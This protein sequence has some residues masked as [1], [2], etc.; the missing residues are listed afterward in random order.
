MMDTRRPRDYVAYWLSRDA[1]RA[2]APIILRFVS[3]IAIGAIL[4]DISFPATIPRGPAFA[5]SMLLRQRIVPND[6]R[7]VV[8]D[9]Y[10]GIAGRFGSVRDMSIEEP[11]IEDIIRQLYE[12]AARP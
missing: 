11:Q 6:R 3:P 4:F 2:L 7:Q 9:G 5:V 10:I 1:G 8:Y 12:G